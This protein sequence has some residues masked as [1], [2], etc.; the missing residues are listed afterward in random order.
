MFAALGLVTGLPP[1]HGSATAHRYVENFTTTQYRDGGT[2]T[3]DWNTAAGKLSL[4]PF[5]PAHAGTH[6]TPANASAVFVDGNRAFVADGASGLVIVDVSNSAAPVLLG[7]YDTPGDAKDVVV[8]GNYA[9][10]ADGGGGLQIVDVQNPAVPVIAGV[11]ATP[12]DARAVVIDGDR[13]FVSDAT[14]G[15]YAVDITD[16]ALPALLGTVALAPAVVVDLDIDGTHLFAA[17]DATGLEIYD[18]ANPA[19]PALLGTYATSNASSV[20]VDGDLALVT[21]G[22]GVKAID[23]SNPVSPALI[24][25]INTG[26]GDAVD[27]AINGDNAYVANG[28]EGLVVLDVTDPSSMAIRYSYDTAEFTRGVAQGG[29]MAYLASDTGGLHIVQVK[30]LVDPIVGSPAGI[31]SPAWR[32][33][34]RGNYALAAGGSGLNIIDISDGGSP[35]PVGN[36][37]TIAFGV[38][39]AGDLAYVADVNGLLVIDIADPTAPS[40]VGSYATAMGPNYDLALAGQHAYLQSTGDLLVL[41]ISNPAAPQLV[42]SDDA[43]LNAIGNELA[44]NYLYVVDTFIG[45]RVYDVSDP[46]NPTEVGLYVPPVSPRALAVSGD[47]AFLGLQGQG[48]VVVDISDPTLPT[49]A[50]SVFGPEITELAVSGDYLFVSQ[51]VFGVRYDDISDPPNLFTVGSIST[52]GSAEGIAPA[53]N[54][55]LIGEGTNITPYLVFEDRWIVSLNIGQ[56]LEVDELDDGIVR[57]R[58]T[59]TQADNVLWRISTGGSFEIVTPD[60][61][62]SQ[63]PLEPLSGELR[64]RAEL[65]P[66]TPGGPV[67]EV[68]QIV[69]DWLYEFAVID[70]VADVPG[71]DGGWLAIDFTRS[72]RDFAVET[73]PIIGY[74]VHQRVDNTALAAG[75]VADGERVSTGAPVVAASREAVEPFVAQSAGMKTYRFDGRYFVVNT[76]A[77]PPGTWEVVASVFAQEIDTYSLNVPTVLDSGDTVP[78]Q[79]YYVSAHTTTPALFYNSPPDSGYSVDNLP[80]APPTGFALAR[81]TGGGNQLDWDPSP[82]PDFQ[83]YNVYRDEMSGFIP[84][85][86]SLVHSTATPSWF[87]PIAEPWRYHYKVSAVDYSGNESDASDPETV[88]GTPG[89]ATQAR[90]AMHQ[91]VPN[92]FNP[93]TEILFD[94]PR[95]G[96]RVTIAIYDVA[97]RRIRTLT[98]D[99]WTAGSHRVTWDG[100]DDG[101]AQVASGVYFYRM[102]APS[103]DTTRKLVLIR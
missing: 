49:L 79:V 85:P 52:P 84:G 15:L 65:S 46:T 8:S 103:F 13:A 3:A 80:P 9:F 92:P 78:H 7:S 21:V 102:R 91:N 31:G 69:I 47:Y 40:L 63:D 28:L 38:E 72:G 19:A 10:V 101:G 58:L 81:N 53:G 54:V 34:V 25:S 55:L 60:G 71:D 24:G 26:A 22:T 23:V 5:L 32:V 39:L 76:G 96:S 89:N 88:T 17:I 18:V 57:V 33:R 93:S 12:N 100:R 67:P 45:I 35:N 37:P 29:L 36:Y 95:A 66:P 64:W 98:S 1:T 62:W 6:D 44:G 2:T 86:T 83:F 97:G 73:S 90:F 61:Q 68:S 14:V 41:D 30:Q 59:T 20:D 75:V 70:Q 77:E 16:P 4:F 56:S 82:E 42:G 74:N 94:V 99:V 50:Q 51:G 27:V 48:L 11:F 43:P 87:D